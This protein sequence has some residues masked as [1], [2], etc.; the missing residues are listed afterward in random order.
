MLAVALTARPDVT[1]RRRERR[2]E[3][4]L[5]GRA[6]AGKLVEVAAAAGG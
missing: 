3:R 5:H 1:A 4:E 2:P 6:S